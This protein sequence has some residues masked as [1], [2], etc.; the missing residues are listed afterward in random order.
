M[1]P[2]IGAQG[3]I[4]LITT[5]RMESGDSGMLG[6]ALGGGGDWRGTCGWDCEDYSGPEVLARFGG[7][8]L[9]IGRV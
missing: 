6:E 2:F 3:K 1:F 5:E 7:G 4:G 8:G 9:S